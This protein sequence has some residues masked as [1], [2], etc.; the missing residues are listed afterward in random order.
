[1]LMKLLILFLV[2]AI[3]AQ[4]LQ[5]GFCDMELEKN[6]QTPHHMDMSD[7]QGHDCCDTD[8]SD[9][10]EGCDSGMNCGMCIV[11]VSALASIPKVTPV[12]SQPFYRNFPSG[13]ILPSHS[14]PPFRPPIS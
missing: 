12:W 3:S 14:S 7:S 5:A 13:M 2:L 4:P 9:T 11:S 1:M 10:R 8:D 6:Q